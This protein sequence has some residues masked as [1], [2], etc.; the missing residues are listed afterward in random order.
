M[1]FG[2]IKYTHDIGSPVPLSSSRTF[3][4][5][6]G[7][8]LPSISRSP[9]PPSRLLWVDRHDI[10][11]MIEQC[12]FCILLLSRHSLFFV[13]KKINVTRIAISRAFGN[14]SGMEV[15]L[16]LGILRPGSPGPGK[17]LEDRAA[18]CSLRGRPS[19]S[20]RAKTLGVLARGSVQGASPP[21]N[22]R[23]TVLR[24]RLLPPPQGLEGTLPSQF[25]QTHTR[26]GPHPVG[27]LSQQSSAS[28][29]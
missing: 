21:L 2:G 28:N 23:S 9:G 13:F 26:R 19:T 25:G 5:P 14:F 17:R 6:E 15:P 4:S 18:S 11:G 3:S 22:F 10:N 16:P 1:P 24:S 8:P 29:L 20:C 12:L 7:N 27:V